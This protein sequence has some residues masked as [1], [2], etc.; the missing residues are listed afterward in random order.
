MVQ[1]ILVSGQGIRNLAKEFKYGKMVQYM[2]DFGLRI[3]LMAREDYIM[4][5]EIYMMEYKFHFIIR[6]GKII[7]RK[8]MEYTYIQ[9]VQDMK[10]IGIMIYK[11]DMELKFGQMVQNMKENIVMELSMVKGNLV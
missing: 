1:F 2:K 11:M 8:V 9:M 7:N 10:E 3:W 4:R 5:T 6:I